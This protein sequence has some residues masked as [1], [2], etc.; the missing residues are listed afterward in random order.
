MY[1]VRWRKS[2]ESVD[3]KQTKRLIRVVCVRKIPE[4]AT[5]LSIGDTEILESHQCLTFGFQC[6]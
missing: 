3:L 4:S 1:V 2:I 6:D 5:S